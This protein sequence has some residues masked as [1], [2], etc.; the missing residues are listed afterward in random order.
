MTTPAEFRKFASDCMRE[1]EC[2][3]SVSMQWTMIGLARIGLE[4][5]RYAEAVR[6]GVEWKPQRDDT[7]RT[8]PRSPLGEVAS[9]LTES[10]DRRGKS[11]SSGR[12]L[13]RR[14]RSG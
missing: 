1:A 4:L 13:C 3:D 2:A 8:T 12:R 14:T 7:F 9:S 11:R 6:D 5:E 10:L